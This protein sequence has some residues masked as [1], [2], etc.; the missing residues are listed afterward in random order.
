MEL[1]LPTQQL[2]MLASC[3][4]GGVVFEEIHYLIYTEAQ[5]GALL[6][7]M[8]GTKSKIAAAFFFLKGRLT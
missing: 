6:T 1:G 3:L 7:P 4:F 5:V 8:V 2:L